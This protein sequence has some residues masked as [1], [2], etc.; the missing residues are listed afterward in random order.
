MLNYAEHV[1][2]VTMSQRCWDPCVVLLKEAI[3]VQRVKGQSSATDI[4]KATQ[5]AGT[6]SGQASNNTEYIQVNEAKL[7]GQATKSHNS[8]TV[9]QSRV[10]HK[11]NR[12]L[13]EHSEMSAEQDKTLQ[14]KKKLNK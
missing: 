11:T 13:G 14:R 4:S 1:R 5:E 7:Q 3:V 8:E 10:K 12:L 9:K 6:V 2:S